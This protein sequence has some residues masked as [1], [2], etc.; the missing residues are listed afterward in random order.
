MSRC[1]FCNSELTTEN[2][3]ISLNGWVYCKECGQPIF[4]INIQDEDHWI[5]KNIDKIEKVD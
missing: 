3:V 4:D 2:I 5:K 1:I